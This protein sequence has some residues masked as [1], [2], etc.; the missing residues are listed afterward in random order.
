M[1]KF[2]SVVIDVDST[3]CGI[4]GI[5]WL[6]GRK[7]AGVRDE[8]AALTER[9]MDGEIALDSVYGRRLSLVAPTKT[10]LDALGAEYERSLARGATD[11]IRR[12][13]AAGIDVHLVS[14]GLLPA[15]RVVA[16][17]AGVADVKVHAVDVKFDDGGAFASF[18]SSSPLTIQ[19]GKRD[20]VGSL[21]LKRPVLMVG[22]GVTDAE[23]RPVVDAFAAF[24]GFVRRESAVAQADYV[25]SSFEEI[26]SLVLQ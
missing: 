1:T 12:M 8:V 17:K 2:N 22:D 11:A 19:N 16:K 26:L 3:L 15:I 4:E 20:V 23:V 5:D 7:S 13:Q 9:A 10:D 21:K 24:T 25:I 6:A 14:G 18:D